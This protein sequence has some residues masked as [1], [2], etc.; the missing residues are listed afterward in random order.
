[1]ITKEF[2]E[3]VKQACDL[4]HM[5]SVMNIMN[6]FE[7]YSS[8]AG[9]NLSDLREQINCILQEFED[10]KPDNNDLNTVNLYF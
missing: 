10:Y 7:W 6:L 3:A 1:M 4:G 9:I 2:K 5:E 8:E